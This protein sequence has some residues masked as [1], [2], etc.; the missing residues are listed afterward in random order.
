MTYITK[1]TEIVGGRLLPSDKKLSASL[2]EVD[3]HIPAYCCWLD[4]QWPD[5]I[6]QRAKAEHHA[7]VDRHGD[8]QAGDQG[9]MPA[10][11]SASPL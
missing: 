6:R 9:I 4:S 1:L 7:I 10:M 3:A 8:E 11:P 5:R 2:L